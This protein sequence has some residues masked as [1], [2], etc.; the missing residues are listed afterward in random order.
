M[1]VLMSSLTEGEQVVLCARDFPLDFSNG[2]HPN[3][4]TETDT[5]IAPECIFHH[6]RG[7]FNR[8]WWRASWKLCDGKFT[9]MSFLLDTGAPKHLYLCSQALNILEEA[10][11]MVEDGDMDLLYTRLFGRKCPVEPTP[12][13]HQPA[14]IIGMKLLKRF[15]LTLY[16]QPPH[17]SFNMD[18]PY[19]DSAAL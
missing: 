9:T 11:Q 6:I 4:Y 13:A 10:G 19:L 17:F 3:D 12:C 18:I 8:L 2:H 5:P 1:S 7:K 14:N 16:E 15:G